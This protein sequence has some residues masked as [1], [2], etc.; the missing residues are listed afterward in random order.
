M[1]AFPLNRSLA[2]GSQAEES[3]GM[4][5]LFPGQ[6]FPEDFINVFTMANIMEPDNMVLV[7]DFINDPKSFHT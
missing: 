3:S 4:E 1:W 7:V 6:D 5:K 2:T